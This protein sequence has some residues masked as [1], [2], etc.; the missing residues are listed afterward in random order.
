MVLCKRCSHKRPILRGCTFNLLLLIVSINMAKKTISVTKVLQPFIL[1]PD[2]SWMLPNSIVR[3]TMDQWLTYGEI[4]L[5][6][7]IVPRDF[8]CFAM[9]NISDRP[10]STS[11][12]PDSTLSLG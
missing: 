11:K 8:A 9:T 6:P 12:L 5:D 3:D 2:Y 10:Y 4:H 1:K 7:C